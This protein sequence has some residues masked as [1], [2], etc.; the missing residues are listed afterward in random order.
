MAFPRPRT[1]IIGLSSFQ[2]LAMF[3]RGVFYT[4]LGVYLRAFLGLSV[5]ETTLFETIPMLLNILFQTFVWGRLADRFQKRKTLIV[6][7]E[8]LAGAGHFLLW[9]LHAGAPD[10]RSSGW[11]IIWG[12]TVIEIFWSMSNIGWSAYVADLY[13]P[14]ERSAVQ[15][16]LASVGGLG[17]IA[18][19]LAGGFLYDR[20]GT[21][22]AGWGF[23]EGAIFFTVGAV[24]LVSVLPFLAMP[25]GGLGRAARKAAGSP[26]TAAG[27][28]PEGNEA[29]EGTGPGIPR[30]GGDAAREGDFR[31]FAVFLVA[32]LLVNSGINSLVAVKAQFLD[33]AEG[34][35]ASARAISLMAN[36]ES[37]AL[38]VAGLS[39]ALLSRRFG[40]GALM[41]AGAASGALYL[42]SYAA[43]PSLALL[44]PL[45]ALKGVSEGLLGAASYAFA[46]ALI[47]PEKRGRWFAAYN[48]TFMLSWGLAA[49]LVTGPVIDG[50]LAAGAGAVTAYRL[51]FLSSAF[52]TLLGLALLASLLAALKSGGVSARRASPRGAGP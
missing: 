14:A 29:A 9:R 44:F 50:L 32:M 15:G 40:S 25:E 2:A 49:T 6:W 17:R 12:L 47:P 33:L 21:A 19:A 11:V 22:Y 48:A 45:S 13:A 46:A 43:S 8:L 38:I 10:L 7:G 16:K 24:M 27:A 51:G 5:T 41:L 30:A 26:R 3:R 39:V 18:G 52:I 42:V 4:F 28:G 35:A 37:G 31:A 36:V 20:A 23:R 1:V 34:F